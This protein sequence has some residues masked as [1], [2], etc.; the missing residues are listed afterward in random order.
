MSLLLKCDHC[1]ATTS[2]KRNWWLTCESDVVIGGVGNGQRL[3][4]HLC[5]YACLSAWAAAKAD[6]ALS[7]LD[8]SLVVPSFQE[9][10]FFETWLES[11]PFGITA[12]APN[13][14]RW[15]ITAFCAGYQWKR[16][17]TQRRRKK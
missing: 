7:M 9:Y 13:M 8:D 6:R 12:V 15:L 17:A 3:L 5:S 2:D 14:R 10:A 1:D 16:R 11:H 4:A